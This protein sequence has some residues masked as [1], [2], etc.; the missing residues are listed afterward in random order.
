MS[1]L[2]VN[3]GNYAN[4]STGDDLRTAFEKS[5]ANFTELDL[6]RVIT[7][8]NLGTGAPIFKEKVGNNLKLRTLVAGSNIGISY[9]TNEI[10]VSTPDSIN[11]LFEDP[12]PT[13]SADLNL[14]NFNVVGLG[15]IYISGDI[16]G[17][18]LSG[19]LDG[20]VYVENRQ[21]NITAV[22]TTTDLYEPIALNGI[23]INGNSSVVNGT[24]YISSIPG[25]SIGIVA[26]VDLELAAVNGTIQISGNT[27][28]TG[29][30]TAV[31]FF[32]N[33]SG[34]VTGNVIGDVNGDVTGNLTGNVTGDVTGNLTGDVTGDVT[35]N[36]FGNTLGVV[37]G[38][39]G[40]SLIGNVT[41][42]VT[43]QV[44]D[45]TNH[46]LYE[47]NDVD[48]VTNPP[49]NGQ[50]LVY[51]SA[52]TKWIPSTITG[53]GGGGGDLDFGSFTSPA[54]FTLDLGAF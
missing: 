17:S 21:L 30:I 1:I 31:S 54:G 9:N 43:G 4:D 51:N 24:S 8:D 19:T 27:I 23:V 32:G 10:T 13:L 29:S 41:G 36:L 6:T 53:G 3:L 7:A 25:D 28:S 49:L 38:L 11:A 37:T 26:D 35:G 46:G 12:N 22:N 52:T 14:N 5:N 33:V 50:S 18:N 47:L 40:S 45:I 15:N 16:V 39:A 2:L 42:N 34:N 44:S 48:F 20:D